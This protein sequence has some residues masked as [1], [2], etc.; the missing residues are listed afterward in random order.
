M[1]FIT[2]EM[3]I[4]N[5]GGDEFITQEEHSRRLKNR[6]KEQLSWSSGSSATPSDDDIRK[7]IHTAVENALNKSVKEQNS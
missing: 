5:D 2:D 6:F 1:P 4:T 7:F 3:E